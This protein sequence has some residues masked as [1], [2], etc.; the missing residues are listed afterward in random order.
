ML[1]RSPISEDE[2]KDINRIVFCSGKI[3]FEL[4]DHISELKLN[5]VYIIRLEQL[6]PFPYEALKQGIKKFIHCELI[7]CQEEPKNIAYSKYFINL[8]HIQYF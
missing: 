3:Y 6:Y 2:Y 1:F 7:W 8:Q 4:Q 5:N